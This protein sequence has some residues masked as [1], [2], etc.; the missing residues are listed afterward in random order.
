MIT[1]CER[2][3]MPIS[4]GEP[5]VRFAHIDRAHADGSITWI[6]SYLHTTGCTLPRP[7]PHEHPDTSDWDPTRSIGI[8][9]SQ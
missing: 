9:R 7:G 2:C 1:I 5:M 3:Y 4:D 6:H 8:H